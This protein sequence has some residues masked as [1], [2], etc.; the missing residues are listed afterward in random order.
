MTEDVAL[1]PQKVDTTAAQRQT[2]LQRL[3]LVAQADQ[4]SCGLS[5]NVPNARKLGPQLRFCI[6]RQALAI[7]TS[8]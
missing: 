7:T 6:A 3:S 5:E 2:Q 4:C 8:I 1:G